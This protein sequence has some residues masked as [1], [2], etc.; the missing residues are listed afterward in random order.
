MPIMNPHA[1]QKA[2][3]T[4]GYVAL[5][6]FLLTLFYLSPVQQVADS[7][8][9]LLLS[10]TL[11]EKGTFQLDDSFQTPF[12]PAIHPGMEYLPRPYHLFPK[13][14]HYY[15]WYPPGGSILAIPYV[16]VMNRFNIKAHHPDWSYNRRGEEIMERLLASLLMVALGCLFLFT[17]RRL[18]PFRWALAL[19][20]L[21]VLGTQVW[22]T[23]S[24]AAWSSTW[25]ILFLQVIIDQ[26]IALHQGHRRLPPIILGTLTAWLYY[27]Q[28]T[29][30]IPIITISCYL[31]SYHRRYF[32]AFALTGAAWAALFFGYSWWNF[33]TLLPNYYLMF[34]QLVWGQLWLIL[35]TTLFSPT[36][37]LLIFL[38]F[39]FFTGYLLL[40]FHRQAVMK[41]V[42][43]IALVN[44]VML[45][46]L[47]SVWE[48]W[49]G[50]YSY[51]PRLQTVML[52]WLMLLSLIGVSAWQKNRMDERRE[53]RE[54]VNNRAHKTAHKNLVWRMELT[55]ALILASL[56]VAIHARGA[57]EFQTWRWNAQI[58]HASF[59]FSRFWQWSNAQFLAGLVDMPLPR[60][61]PPYNP[62]DRIEFGQAAADPYLWWGWSYPE[63]AFR[64]SD[65]EKAYIIW[66][67]EGQNISEIQLQCFPFL[68]EGKRDKQRITISLNGQKLD[69]LI[70]TSPEP[71][72]HRIPVP[73]GLMQENNV[74]EFNLS[75]AAAPREFDLNEDRRKL[76]IGVHWLEM[77]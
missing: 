10:E 60:I 12:D 74:L 25:G 39:L 64:W 8:Y 56:S 59:E 34:D 20:L 40:R 26:L 45:L 18:L 55:V 37:G 52:P 44:I 73:E 46:I 76:A 53:A 77:K 14:G 71:Q 7:H 58:I 3:V 30:S 24:R 61:Y 75:K 66:K 4:F 23:A 9:S 5:F 27:I 11:I 15:Y 22:S 41:P 69:K 50:G 1:L 35:L 2:S 54:T 63:G 33:G 62:G 48:F 38:P 21:G 70:L 72:L 13:D 19:A 49:W 65:G 32:W 57:C 47:L 16:W 43:T 31:L 29:F 17:F 68:I 28:P 42:M 51:G 6:T 67:L 36:R